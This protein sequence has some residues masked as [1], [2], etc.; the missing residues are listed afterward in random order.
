MGDV[1]KA[2][3]TKLSR[4]V[5]LKLLASHLLRDEEARERF[6]REAQAAAALSHP[7]VTTV[8]EIDEADGHTFLVLELVEGETLEQRIEN[9]PLPLQE[10]LDIGRQIAEGLQAAH[11]KG[12]VHRDI[13]PGNILITPKGRV[14]ILDFGLALLTEGSKLTQLHTTVGTVAYMSPE[15]SQAGDV[16]H[17]TDVWAL[18]CLLYEMVCGQRP[19]Q[20]AYDQAVV[21]SI[22]N[23][24]PEP[25]TSLR[26]GVPLELEL[27]VDK[28]LAKNPSQRFQSTADLIVD[29]EAIQEKLRS[30]RSTI[31]KPV[32][33]GAP[34]DVPAS[35]EPTATSDWVPR[36][37]FRAL[38]AGAAIASTAALALAVLWPDVGD[39][40]AI[41]FQVSPQQ[42]GLKAAAGTVGEPAISPDGR[43]LALLGI[44]ANGESSIYLRSLDQLDWRRLPGTERARFPF[45]SPDSQFLAFFADAT[46]KKVAVNG[47][48]SFEICEVLDPTGGDWAD[49]EGGADGVIVF[50]ERWQVGLQKVSASGGDPVV[51]ANYVYQG[52]P[53]S[54]RFLPDGVHFMY[55]L[56]AFGREPTDG[57][58]AIFVGRI[59]DSPI[60]ESRTTTPT[61]LLEADSLPRYAPSS[62]SS[63]SGW[64]LYIR[65]SALMAHP[66][67]AELRQLTGRPV[68]VADQVNLVDEVPQGDF[69][70]SRTGVLAYRAKT[71]SH[72]VALT[73]FDRDGGAIRRLVDYPGA[74]DPELS[75]DATSI[76]AVPWFGSD[77]TQ[78]TDIWILDFETGSQRPFT[79]M[80][81]WS[82]SPRWSPDGS[83]IAFQNFTQNRSLLKST[84][85]NSEAKL[86][87]QGNGT[88][89]DWSRDGRYLL[90]GQWRSRREG[91]D[92]GRREIWGME[93]G[94]NNEPYPILASEDVD[95]CRGQFSPDGKWFS[96]DAGEPGELQ[97]F[98]GRF[99]PDG[100]EIQVTANGGSQARWRG[101]GK[102]LYY[103]S[104]DDR[105]M[106]VEVFPGDPI[107]FGPSRELFVAPVAA[108]TVI[109]PLFYDVT[110]DGQRFIIATRSEVDDTPTTVIVNWEASLQPQ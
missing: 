66:F 88:P 76:A 73:W 6:Q 84:R 67:D 46:L 21:Y 56:F 25:L 9:G 23:E 29:V 100:S 70:V 74:N 19:F 33:T 47:G 58:D 91:P 39:A 65:D 40:P 109:G 97:V 3:D 32:P 79:L 41:Q 63:D 16:D 86:L 13:K 54:V 108:R 95:Y 1:W 50:A 71:Q 35:T 49:P 101:D 61:S 102:E 20:A 53:R 27:L 22:V 69:S 31:H 34:G 11:A 78:G 43:T 51:V 24:A 90:F 72:H 62:S 82:V 7:N 106:A 105:M 104:P 64:L 68:V 36:A 92:G 28:C 26:T 57:D 94:D 45:W 38:V 48:P 14:K 77:A 93:R 75:P 5:A 87:A 10:A 89:T 103:L 12:I 59:N 2:E 18:G 37:R 85:G 42:D 110:D 8:F 98:V 107:R 99:P 52:A 96:Y 55:R 15:Q 80:D 44:D 17:R 60:E 30:G 81:G 4:P 83:Q